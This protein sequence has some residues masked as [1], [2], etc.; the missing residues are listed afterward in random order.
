MIDN[1][2]YFF[3]EPIYSKKDPR[4]KPLEKH[5]E[6]S[7]FVYYVVPL[8][9]IAAFLYIGMNVLATI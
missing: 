5:E 9:V 7:G 2:E 3:P 8:M 6:S 4:Y 1:G